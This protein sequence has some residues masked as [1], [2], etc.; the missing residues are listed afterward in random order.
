MR[1]IFIILY[2]G[3]LASC[4]P[5]GNLT[6]GQLSCEYLENPDVV[7]VLRPRLSWINVAPEGIRG[8]EQSAWQIRVASSKRKLGQPDLWDSGKNMSVQSTRVS[9]EG[10]PLSSRQECWWQVRVWDS[11]GEASSWSEPAF[12]RMGLLEPA[13]WSAS[14]IGAPWQGEEALPKPGGGPDGRPDDFGPPAPLLRK[15]FA[16]ESQGGLCGGL[17]YRAGLF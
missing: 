14:W 4:T 11:D 12:W 15:E 17:C 3:L 6:P 2:A 10:V 16:G 5:G 8:Q 1:Y 9:Y 7:D 13:D